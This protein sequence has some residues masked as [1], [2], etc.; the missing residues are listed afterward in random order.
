MSSLQQTIIDAGQDFEW[1]PTTDRMIDAVARRLPTDFRSLMDIGAGDGRVLVA[2]G[3]RSKDAELYAIEKSP[4][5]M[6]AQPCTITPARA[7]I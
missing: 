5:L 3:R 2:I 6:Q 4:L 7:L 1:Y